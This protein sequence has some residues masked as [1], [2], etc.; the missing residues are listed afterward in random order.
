MGATASDSRKRRG[1]RR[2]AD[3]TAPRWVYVRAY[4]AVGVL[5]LM[6][7]LIAYKAYGLQIKDGDRY[8][9]IARQQHLRTVELP[10]PRGVIYDVKGRTLAMTTDAS[11]V[12][13]NPR[14]VTD[15]V[16]TAEALAETLGM[17]VRDVEAKL[18]S[19]RYFVWIKRQVTTEEANEL[20]S[21][22]MRGVHL[23]PEPRRFYPGKKLGGTVLGFA[24]IDGKGLDGVELTMDEL[25]T[26]DRAK[27]R[28]VR[29]ASG[30][31]MMA[32]G[33]MAARPG[34]AVTLTID[35]SVQYIAEKILDSAARRFEAK[36]ATA[37]VLDVKTGRV[38]AMANWPM[39]DS[40]NPA[41][42]LRK[43]ARNRAL[44]DAYEMGSTMKIFSIAAALDA[45]VCK[46]DDEIDLQRGR[47][48]IGSKTIGDTHS[49]KSLTVKG[50][51]KRSS[52]VG[53]IKI[54]RLTGRERLGAA[55]RK[56]GFGRKTGIE[57]PGERRGKLKKPSKWAEIELATI[58]FGMGMTAT[59]LQLAA[60]LAA[61]GNDGVYN[62]PRIVRSVR[63]EKG[64][65]YD[66]KPKGRRIMKRDTARIMR[67]MM[68]AVFDKGKDGGTARTVNVRGY[69]AGGKTGTAHKVDPDTKK[70][71]DELYLASFAGLAP[72]NNPK[73]AVVVVLDEPNS[74]THYG[75]IVA[76]P[77]FA[78]IASETLR[79]MGVPAGLPDNINK[80]P[81]QFEEQVGSG[82]D[83]EVSRSPVKDSSGNSAGPTENA[84]DDEPPSK[85][86]IRVPNFHGM[87]LAKALDVARRARIELRIKGSGRGVGQSIKPGWATAPVTVQVRFER[88]KR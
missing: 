65:V 71:S 24:G 7:C 27:L 2:A 74:D 70:Y 50:V 47:L 61:I 37:V 23:T 88:G 53:T 60:G 38:I 79:Y 78:R 76:A 17:D 46:P 28:A 43:R 20:R 14:E 86:S 40:N 63:N 5:T 1:R 4:I 29:D 75:A 84:A 49:D 44:T 67:N 15:V 11:S 8:R 66:H 45:G 80:I 55:L 85:N 59:T 16:A 62:E 10:A 25:L 51:F 41:A 83:L 64:V 72:I 42:G 12:F 58:S 77:A 56:Y 36:A 39:Y 18:S 48:R 30:G 73:I 26:G 57:L 81:P 31:I 33:M 13:A 32:D 54:A 35:Q 52:N 87:S 22:K 6:F 19:R 34:S 69:R 82:S 21:I 9:R 3:V 68:A